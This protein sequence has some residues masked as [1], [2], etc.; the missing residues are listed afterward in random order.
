M[1]G[2]IVCSEGNTLSVCGP[3]ISCS[4]RD[5]YPSDAIL[6]LT[7][8]S[9]WQLWAQTTKLSQQSIFIW[10]NSISKSC[11]SITAH[12][13]LQ[14]VYLSNVCLPIWTGFQVDKLAYEIKHIHNKYYTD[15]FIRKAHT[16]GI[17]L[18]DC[19]IL[20][21]YTPSAAEMWLLWCDWTN[22][23]SKDNTLAAGFRRCLAIKRLSIFD[24]QRRRWTAQKFTPLMGGHQDQGRQSASVVQIT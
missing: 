9:L 19:W 1:V 12:L 20:C 11:H 4:L 5:A 8:K 15:L 2:F 13:R 16:E 14:C 7:G 17:S 10:L 21:G 3:D 23:I 24:A 22:S 6:S 18:P